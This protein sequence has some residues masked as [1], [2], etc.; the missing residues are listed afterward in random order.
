MPAH[1]REFRADDYDAAWAL[2]SS[3][4]G[5]GL[6]DADARAD[7]ERFLDRN[8][9][10]SFVAVEAS[11]LIGTILCGHDGR[12]GLI[13]H[14]V[15]AEHYRRK[16]VGRLLVERALDAL[17]ANGIRKCHL[18]AFRDNAM[19]SA[20]WRRIGADERSDVYTFSVCTSRAGSG[21]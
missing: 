19:A 12:R 13:H 8:A 20:F 9:G 4:A 6:S 1:I 17:Q 2:W 3:T 14:L 15:V 5:V 11:A 18:L 7:I 16:G 21:S 10:L